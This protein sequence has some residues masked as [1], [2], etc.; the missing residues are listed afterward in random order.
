MDSQNGVNDVIAD[1]AGDFGSMTSSVEAAVSC[2]ESET[3]TEYNVRQIDTGSG[4]QVLDCKVS[5]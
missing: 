3:L 2:L 4:G 5:V 1:Q